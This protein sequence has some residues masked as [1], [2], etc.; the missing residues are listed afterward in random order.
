MTTRIPVLRSPLTSWSRAEED[1]YR[2]LVDH[3][4]GTEAIPPCPRCNST[5]NDCEAGA[6]LRRALRDATT[7]SHAG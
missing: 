6:Q 5:E 4:G 3:A 2:A 1:A 7:G